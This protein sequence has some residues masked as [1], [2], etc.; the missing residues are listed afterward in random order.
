MQVGVTQE[1]D[2]PIKLAPK[3]K[4]AERETQ[5]AAETLIRFSEAEIIKDEET[6]TEAVST[7]DCAQ[8][9]EEN[10][11]GML[12]ALQKT[13]KK[14]QKKIFGV[15]MIEG[16]D[17]ATK[18]YTGLPNWCIF[19]HIFMFLSPFITPSCSLSFH[20]ELLLVLMKLRLNLLTA[21]LAYRCGIS[22]GL[23]SKIFQKWLEVMY[24]RM[25]FLITWPS[26]EVLQQNMP[27]VFKQ[28][29]PNCRVIIDCSEIF[30][31]TPSSFAARSKT[32]SNYKKHNT[33]KFLIGITPCGTIS[34]LSECWGGRIS[35][36]NLTQESTFL[37]LLEPGDVVLADR[38][39]TMSEDIA[40]RGAKLII[41]AFTRGKTQLSQKDVEM[42]K[43]LSKVRIHVERVIGLMKNRYTILKGP[44]PLNTLKHKGDTGV[45]NIDKILVVCSAL[46]NLGEP[47]VDCL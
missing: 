46:T 42:S 27:L 30:I 40:L 2:G 26:R 5:E 21:D 25:R 47:I 32:Y 9:T 29:Y 10:L 14:L 16:N 34:Y 20:D 35:D 4:E 22:I 36:K 17:N 24:V 15:G 23:V 43:Q 45:A 8:Q 37:S 18:F 44:I 12:E 38:G 11:P 33:V 19:L 28:L 31:E 3:A 7:V 6:Q 39:F 13:N 1:G 41:P